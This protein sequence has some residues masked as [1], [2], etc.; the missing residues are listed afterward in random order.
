MP[1]K[2]G[3]SVDPE[4]ERQLAAAGDDEAVEAAFSLRAPDENPLIEPAEVQSTVDRIVKAAQDLTGQKIHDLNVLPRAQ[5]FILAAPAKVVREVLKCAEIASA[6]ANKQP[7]SLT[8]DPVESAP[9]KLT[10]RRGGKLER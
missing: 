9:K 3:I 10:P 5:Q 8:I 1:K 7:E 6:L 4:L 2:P